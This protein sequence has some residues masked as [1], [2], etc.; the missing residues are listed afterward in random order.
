[1]FLCPDTHGGDEGGLFAVNFLHCKLW[2]Y[3]LVWIF[4][5]GDPDMHPKW[6]LNVQPS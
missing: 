3:H 1:M 6:V 5:T 4:Q 2:K